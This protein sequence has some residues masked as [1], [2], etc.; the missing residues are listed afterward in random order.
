MFVVTLSPIRFDYYRYAAGDYRRRG[1]YQTALTLY[2]KAN[3]YAPEGEDRK[4]RI[5]EMRRKVKQ[6]DRQRR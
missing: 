2:E 5:Q 4:E 6:Q 1:D 3:R